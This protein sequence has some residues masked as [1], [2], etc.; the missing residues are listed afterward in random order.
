[1]AIEAHRG[2]AL[3]ELAC[4]LF[5]LALLVSVLCAFAVYTVRTLEVQNHARIGGKTTDSVDV[6]TIAADYVFGKTT[7]SIREP[8]NMPSQVILK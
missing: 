6:D 8:I 7:L 2:Q 4:G 5:A 3:M 1:M